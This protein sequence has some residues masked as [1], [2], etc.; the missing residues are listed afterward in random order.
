[1][2]ACIGIAG[3]DRFDQIEKWLATGGW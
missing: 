1:M 3:I 2:F